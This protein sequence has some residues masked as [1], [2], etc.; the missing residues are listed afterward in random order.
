VSSYGT[1]HASKA[2][3][4]PCIIFDASTKS[5]PHEVVLNEIT[6]TEFEANIDFGQAKMKL[7]T[8]I[9]NWR[10]ANPSRK[11]YLA[12]ADITAFFQY[13]RIHTDVTGAFGYVADN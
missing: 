10:V 9:Y 12:L 4:N 13:L 6:T 7:L 3:K 5:D 8:R 11:I 2:W 1:R